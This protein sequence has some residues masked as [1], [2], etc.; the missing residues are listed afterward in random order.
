[1]LRKRITFTLVTG[2]LIQTVSGMIVVSSTLV[3][4]ATVEGEKERALAV[5]N[6]DRMGYLNEMNATRASYCK[7][8]DG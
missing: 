4:I 3:S 8:H 6:Q 1:M 5:T 2:L 7:C